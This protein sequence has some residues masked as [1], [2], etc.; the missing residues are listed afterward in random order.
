MQTKPLSMNRISLNKGLKAISAIDRDIKAALAMYG[1]PKAES[2]PAGFDTLVRTIVN[3][4]LSTKAADSIMLRLC[5]LLPE[6]NT[7]SVLAKRKNTLCKTG[8]SQRKADYIR[9]LAKA[10]QQ[11]TFKLDALADMD[12]SSAIREIVKLH[13]FGEWSA[14]IYLLF[15]LNRQDIF[16]AS[17]L[18]LQIAL[19]KI[20]HLSEKPTP[21]TARQLTA[22]WAPWRSAGSLF[23]WHAYRQMRHKGSSD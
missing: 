8:L 11:G 20:K 23:L 9:G 10:I 2:Q 21:E 19:Q 12:D 7:A 3:Q 13:G 22:G 18:A 4:Q 17:D 14:Q 6:L 15:S 16:P 1:K 5:R